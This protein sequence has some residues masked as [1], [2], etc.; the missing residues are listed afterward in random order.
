MSSAA[1]CDNLSNYS[2]SRVRSYKSYKR[3]ECDLIMWYFVIKSA[4]L[5]YCLHSLQSMSHL[6]CLSPD[7]PGSSSPLNNFKGWC[8]LH[9]ILYL[10]NLVGFQLKCINL[11]IRHPK[12]ERRDP[13][14]LLLLLCHAQATPP[15]FWSGVDW[16][17]VV[18]K[19]EKF[20]LENFS[21]NFQKKFN[22]F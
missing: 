3:K 11:S 7:L 17:A 18:K 4:L 5:S 10:R 19:F 8:G 21:D 9:V 2:L 1:W 15:E 13:V 14:L 22:I 6:Y 12:L 20:R 16:R